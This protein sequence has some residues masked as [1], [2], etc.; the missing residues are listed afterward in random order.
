[1]LDAAH[2]MCDA[3][4][5]QY[6]IASEQ[7]KQERDLLRIIKQLAKAKLKSYRDAESFGSIEGV[8]KFGGIAYDYVPN[9]ASSS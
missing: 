5:E 7:R 3:F 1:M 4:C 8:D 6:D 9:Y 2:N